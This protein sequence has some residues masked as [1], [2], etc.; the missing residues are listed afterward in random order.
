MSQTLPTELF[1][2]RAQGFSTPMIFQR[3][4]HLEKIT[5]RR[6]GLHKEFKMYE[7]FVKWSA[8]DFLSLYD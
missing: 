4:G 5:E 2:P 7:A 3:D 1:Q 8:H 6:N